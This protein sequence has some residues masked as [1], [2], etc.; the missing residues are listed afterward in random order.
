MS[1]QLGAAAEAGDVEALARL[2]AAGAD[3][4][5]RGRAGRTALVEATIADRP[6]AVEILLDHGAD[7]EAPCRALGMT[8]LG[9]AADI[10]SSALVRLLVARGA[11]L[12]ATAS[13]TR[14]TALMTAAQ[15]G[16]VDVVRLL[17]DAGADPHAV[18]TYGDNAWRLADENGHAG[19]TALLEAAGS[20]APP[21]PELPAALPWPQVA[22]GADATDDPVTVVR[23]FVLAMHEWEVD[24][25]ASGGADLEAV[26]AQAE[27]IRTRF[28]TLRPRTARGSVGFPA[29]YAPED[30]LVA[31]RRVS[32]TRT[33]VEIRQLLTAVMPTEHRFVVTRVAG[34]WRIDSVT[35]RLL[36]HE[37]WER[38]YL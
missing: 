23:A 28:C 25:H 13:E 37:K 20:G 14:R 16:H 24:A 38:G 6:A 27:Q 15:G 8:A 19:V 30:E 3:V 33:E 10:G 34:R 31:V 36:F 2:L 7:V 5:R 18:D 32:A 29:E 4:Q 11:D 1:R 35:E 21:P 26:W 22:P 9:W 12:A 17:L